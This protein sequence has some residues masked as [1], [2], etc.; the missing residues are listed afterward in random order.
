MQ[1]CDD[2]LRRPARKKL[3]DHIARAKTFDARASLLQKTFAATTTIIE[4]VREALGDVDLSTFPDS[5]A[6]MKSILDH[7][8]G[9]IEQ[10]VARQR[11]VL[12][13]IQ[14]IAA[15]QKAMTVVRN[16]RKLICL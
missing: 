5:A 3:E 1:A 8:S 2:P 6:L 11:D 15:S 10:A 16:I 14:G 12:R 13:L 7:V 9:P 4:E